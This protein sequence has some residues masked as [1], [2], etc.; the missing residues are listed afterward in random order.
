MGHALLWEK[1]TPRK[2]A[3]ARVLMDPQFKASYAAGQVHGRFSA[4]MELLTWLPEDERLQVANRVAGL[5]ED[6]GAAILRGIASRRR[7]QLAREEAD[8]EK[9]HARLG[10]HLDAIRDVEAWMGLDQHRV[11]AV[12]D[13]RLFGALRAER[14]TLRAGKPFPYDETAKAAQIFLIQ[15]DWSALLGDATV[16]AE[17]VRLPADHCCFEATVS[18]RRVCLMVRCERG[19]PV[20]VGSLIQARHMWI[21]GPST[22]WAE[23]SGALVNQV[24]AVA[25]CLDAEVV[26]ADPIRVPF[27]AGASRDLGVPAYSYHVLRL[28]KSARR[29]PSAEPSGRR[30]RLHFRRGHWRRYPTHK[31]WVRWCLVGDPSLG[32]V[33]K[34]YAL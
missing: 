10:R 15:H 28:T 9:E 32:L 33:E 8:M 19:E 20:E 34:D 14:I 12:T 3:S 21:E 25:A 17:E 22:P 6:E 29:L 5:P 7:A 31:T 2:S 27:S 11:E 30:R 1:P 13:S 16:Q 24:R 26:Y 4:V 23:A 18:G